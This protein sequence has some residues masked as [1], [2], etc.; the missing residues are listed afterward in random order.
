MED[1][2]Q[3]DCREMGLTNERPLW[4]C[5]CPDEPIGVIGMEWDGASV[6]LWPRIEDIP[7]M[8]D[9]LEL[10]ATDRRQDLLMSMWRKMAVALVPSWRNTEWWQRPRRIAMDI[11]SLG[12]PEH[13]E[14]QKEWLRDEHMKELSVLLISTENHCGNLKHGP[15]MGMH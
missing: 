10:G 15:N 7:T 3:K 1:S 4:R 14:L 9:L 13:K 6:F 12:R 8:V 2:V 5:K 11:L